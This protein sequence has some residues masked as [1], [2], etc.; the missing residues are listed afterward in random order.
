V[1]Y[2][3]LLACAA[4][5]IQAATPRPNIVF[6]LMDDLGYSELGCYGNTFNETPNLDA[7][8]SQGMRLTNAYS[9]QTVSSPTRA[10]LMTGYYPQRTGIVDYLRPNDTLHLN[11]ACTTL[12]EMLKAQGYSTAL[13][14]K[15][16]L[17]GYVAAGAPYE[18]SPD[19]HGFDFVAL[20]EKEGIGDGTYFHPYH[21]NK[22]IE[23]L[24]APQHEF[25]VD[26]INRQAVD[27]IATQDTSKPFFLMIS[28]YA[29]HTQLHGK[30]EDVE[31]FAAKPGAGRSNPG[32]NNPQNDP[33]LKWPSDYAAARNNPHLAA[34]LY[35]ADQGVGLIINELRRKGLYE[36]TI[37][38]FTSDNGGETRV[39]S[40]APLRDGKSSLYEGGVRIP[41]IVSAPGL[42]LGGRISNEP[43]ITF[44]FYPTLCQILGVKNPGVEFDGRS[45]W[46]TWKN[47]SAK[48]SERPLFWHYPL[49][50]PH[51]LGG[52]SCGSVR[53]GDWKLMEFFDSGEKELYNLRDD[54]GEER[55]LLNENPAIVEKLYNMMLEWRKDVGAQIKGVQMKNQQKL[56]AGI[57]KEPFGQ[58]NG[59]PVELYTLSNKNGIVVKVTNYGGIIT[60]LHVPDRNGE[61][62]DVVLGFDHLAGYLSPEY[63]TNNPYFGAIIGRFCTRI[64]KGK[65]TLDG[66]EYTLST[67]D[68]E[69]HL[70]GGNTGF[71]A[72]VWNAK[73]V[74][75]LDGNTLELTYTSK[76]M[77]EG[78]PGNLKVTV[79]YTLTNNNELK[80][81]YHAVTDKATPCN[82]T[83]HSYFNL[84]AG[85]QPTIA[86]HELVIF[87]GKYTE[88][89]GNWIPTGKLSEVANTPMDFTTPHKIGERIH[90]DFNQLK[91]DR[92]GYAHSWE[93]YNKDGSPALV[94]TLYEPESGRYMEVFTTEPAM[95]FYAG[96]Y[97]DGTLIGKNNVTYLMYSGLC[98][99]TQ[100]LPDSPNQPSF[101]STILRP[102]EI[103]KTQTVF[104]FSTK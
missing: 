55:N 79:T 16:H 48:A 77:E 73:P 38:I 75:S 44:D 19:K 87:A 12:P 7:L 29:V 88:M 2:P 25:L 54:Q 27:Y 58:Y 40:N 86:D 91:H 13:I 41:M 80:I 43:F 17:T 60:E 18:S 42:L 14:G 21:F 84:S 96:S 56:K 71:N 37:I 92:G 72:V 51:F 59:R 102:G 33:Y 10:A 32:R 45:A 66:V 28:H 90:A 100:H 82:L 53:M 11:E 46:D 93:L 24:L 61:M 52:R 15:W 31:R 23:K 63:K 74:E 98:L 1:K 30:P 3:L 49:D 20:S 36:N 78:Y 95:H 35:T 97:L 76:D 22:D 94:T 83:N 65:F 103:Y 70:H 62:G 85:K 9:A 50:E 89:D 57:L 69:N 6:V 39:T 4:G 101:P 5:T 47:P 8:A 99:E 64:A 34:Q 26:R 104:K 81:D 68:G 67:N